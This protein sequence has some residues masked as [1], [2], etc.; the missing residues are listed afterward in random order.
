VALLMLLLL[1]GCGPEPGSGSGSSS[2]TRAKGRIAFVADYSNKRGPFSLPDIYTVAA[3]GSSLT[4]LTRTRDADSPTWAPDGRRLAYVRTRELHGALRKQLWVMNAD[5][6]HQ[7]RL[8]ARGFLHFPDWSPVGDRIAYQVGGSIRVLDVTTGQVRDLPRPPGPWLAEEPRWSTDGRRIAFVGQGTGPGPDDY[9]VTLALFTMNAD[10]SDVRRV[11]GTHDLLGFD[12]SWANGLLA[13]G[14]GLDTRDGECNGDVFVTAPERGK[15]TRVVAMKCRQ[16][17][18]AWSPDGR[19][20]VFESGGGLWVSDRDGAHAHE[21]L[22]RPGDDSLTLRGAPTE[23][24]WQPS[25]KVAP[26][27]DEDGKRRES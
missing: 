17:H 4:R 27:G 3:D 21:I 16:A 8:A 15:P 13:Y 26:H 7:R 11:A 18:P 19:Q 24:D 23:P 20:I 5:G 22:R 14:S 2:S 25:T 12:W 9:T 6:S 10:G 1:A